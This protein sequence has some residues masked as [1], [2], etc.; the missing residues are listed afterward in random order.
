M[1]TPLHNTIA[2]SP[3]RSVSSPAT[4]V[5]ATDPSI[6]IDRMRPSWV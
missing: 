4:E 6:W 1:K 2:L 3:K 5:I